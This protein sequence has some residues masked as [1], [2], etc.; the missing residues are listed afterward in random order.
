M[1]FS[2]YS[3]VISSRWFPVFF[4]ITFDDG[5]LAQCKSWFLPGQFLTGSRKPQQTERN[6]HLEKTPTNIKTIQY[7]SHPNHILERNYISPCRKNQVQLRRAMT[8][9]GSIPNDCTIICTAVTK[10]SIKALSPIMEQKKSLPRC[11]L[12]ISCSQVDYKS[13]CLRNRFSF[14]QTAT[15]RTVFK[16]YCDLK[17][18]GDGIKIISGICNSPDIT[19]CRHVQA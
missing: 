15:S 6:L 12:F 5:W 17:A 13:S 2:C 8:Y 11:D 10:L 14:N 16:Q 19:A 7:S 1:C 9:S 4:W 3:A 18:H